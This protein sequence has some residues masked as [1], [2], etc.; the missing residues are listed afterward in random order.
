VGEPAKGAISALTKARLL[1]E[2]KAGVTF[3]HDSILTEWGLVRGWLADARDDRLLSAHLERDAARWMRSKD[4]TELWRK[5]RL[6]AAVDLRKRGSVTLSDDA[7][8][9]IAHSAAEE[10]KGKVIVGS[11]A[12]V[13]IALIVG[14]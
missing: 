3:V 4:V 1:T 10:Q 14:G 13:V 7:L 9:F 2:E 12:A 8:S 11:I 5:G 6:A